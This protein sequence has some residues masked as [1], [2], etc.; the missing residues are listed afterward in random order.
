[1][2]DPTGSE[3]QP[4]P[5]TGADIERI[6]RALNEH[7]VEYVIIGG[8]AVQFF[9]LQRATADID[10]LVDPSPE[11][12]ER[13]RKAL[14][15]LQDRAVLEVEPTDVAAYAVVRVADE[16]VVDLLGSACGVT[17]RDITGDIVEAAVGTAMARFPSV[18]ALLRT[19]QT[20]RPKDAADREFLERLL[21]DL[22]RPDGNA[23]R[24]PDS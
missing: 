3:S 4:R 24:G 22:S 18:H 19:K 6:V 23:A 2:D 1:M 21:Y 5:P 9:G 20:L 17:F 15:V 13:I 16:V 11:N 14:C 12:V 8:I 10:L 7:G